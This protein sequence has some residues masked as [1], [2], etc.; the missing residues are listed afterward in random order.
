VREGSFTAHRAA[1]ASRFL[2]AAL[3][4][5]RGFFATRAVLLVIQPFAAR[6]DASAREMFCCVRDCLF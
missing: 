6:G 4:I 5:G 1:F 2:H 3:V